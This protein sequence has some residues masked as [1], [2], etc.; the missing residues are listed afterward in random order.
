MKK[1][2]SQESFLEDPMTTL[3]T[4][5]KKA[6]KEAKEVAYTVVK[7]NGTLVPFRRERILRAIEAAFRDTKNVPEPTQFDTDVKKTIEQ[8]TD[9]VVKQVLLLASK[10]ACLTVEGIQDVVEVTLMKN[11]HHD[12][13][14]DYIVYRDERQSK[15]ETSVTNL[16]IYR[17]DK[18]T[19]TRFNPMKIASSIERAFRKARKI[20]EQSPDEVV[21]AVNLLTQKI[22]L[23]MSELSTKGDLLYIDMIEDRIERELMNEKFFDVAK[24]YILYRADKA[25]RQETLQS[26]PA[27]IDENATVRSFD[28]L[29]VDNV[30]IKINEHMIRNKFAFACRGLEKLT[31]ID[32]LLETSISQFY[33]GMKQHEADLAN[34]FSAKSKIEKE[35]AY[36]QVASRLL[37]D[38]LYRETVGL[39]ASDATLQKAH[40]QY[41]KKYIKEGISVERVSPK[42]LDFDLDELAAAMDLKRDDLFTYL[43]LQTLYDRYFIHHEQRRLET[44]QIFWMRVSMGLALN[45]GE[46]KNK[47]AIEFYNVLSQFHFTSSTP[48]LFNSG[49]LH[50][51]LS[52]CY[53]STVMDDLQHIFKVI[54]DDAQLSKY[55]GGLGNDWTNVRATGARIKGTNGNSQGVVPF[56]KVAND[57]AVAVNQ[58]FAPETLIYTDKGTKPISDIAIGDLVLGISGTYREVTEKF[59]YNQHDPMVAI[60]VKHSIDPISV[61]AGHPFYAIRGV[62]LEQANERTMQWLKKGKIKCEWVEAGQLQRGDYIAQVI[63]KETVAVAGMDEEDARLYG[64]LLGDGHMSK[65]G[66]QWGISGNPKSDTHLEFIRHYLNERG[67]H[68]WE[69]ECGD[70]YI[71][72]HWASGR[73]AV[74]DATTGRIV[75][76]GAPTLPFEY[77]DLYDAQGR[78]HIA[79]RLA[80]LPRPQ[81]L[82]LVQGL[83]ETD[84]NVSRGKEITF[85]NT[86]Q[87]LVEGLRYQ[88]LR[89]GVP[90]AGKLRVRKNDHTGRRSDGSLVH[91]KGETKN[92]DLR[93][94]A[95]PELAKLI[96]C[97]PVKKFN[98]LTINDHIFTRVEERASREVA[99]FV[100]DL[101]VEGDE[102]Y[103]TTSGLAHNGGKRKGA[104][105]AYL[106]TW[107]LDIEDFLELRKNTGDERRRTHDMNTANWIPDLFMKRVREGGMWTL[108]SP[109][110]VPDLHDLYGSA[111]EARYVAYEKM[112]ETGKIKLFKK[113]EAL[114]LWRKMLS[115]LFETGHPWITF[116]DPSNIRS[117]QDHVGVVH[118]SNLCTEILLNTSAQETAVCNLGS[119]N[120]AMHVTEK[121]LDEKQ[122]SSTIR[123]AVRMLDN[124]IDIN[125]Y[126]TVEAK[127]ANA[128][129]RPIGLGFMG[130]QDALY[131]QN[132][133]Y[134]SHAAVEFADKSMEM[135][136]YYAILAS[137]ELAQERGTYQTYKGSKWDRGLLPIDT[138]DI[139]EKERGVKVDIDRSMSM[140]WEPVRSAVKKYGMR[141]SNTMAIAPTATIA[142]ITGVIPSNEPIYKHLFVKSNLSGEFTVTNPH[143]V[144][145]LKEQNLWDDEMV[146]D[147]KYFDGSIREIER[148]PEEIRNLFLTAFEVEPEWIIECGARRQKW[149]DMGQSL[150]LYLAEP[151]GKKL[152]QM[153][154]L[155][156]EK[157]LKTTYYLRTL[158][159]TQIEKSS[160]D[161]NKRG[162]QPRWM[163]SKSASSNIKVD[164]AEEE[165]PK[166]CNLGEGCESCQ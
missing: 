94:P 3:K 140:N 72:I 65:E 63:P 124:V 112:T 35:P 68:F 20:E 51:Q 80:H 49:T 28:I 136:S 17:R 164:R 108:F 9:L 101:K 97:A 157:G 126:P 71:Q 25:L 21:A 81:A 19:P 15:R 151:S 134:A 106:E 46:Q 42:L 156:W 113:V 86:S 155:A 55:A 37:L 43:G 146:D 166:A 115:M 131:I 147:L 117:P 161:I 2:T 47:R 119:V 34:I 162:L 128:R 141:N 76:S 27:A 75:G 84:G 87:P 58:C 129:H 96:D 70:S 139:L 4:T 132:I 143:L 14:R 31:S 111:F 148:V 92:Y 114:Y 91:F 32:E 104:M 116:K 102:S 22:V 88:M 79:P 137:T 59:A 52:S 83:L 62:P 1:T 23:E 64:I 36:S 5:A 50:S 24:N 158:G 10:G 93:I 38:V 154:L 152:H 165:Q 41:F 61:T 95:I 39:P 44:P 26:L 107:H 127:T 133:S 109:S 78:K 60:T 67:I 159:A 105:C 163:K 45:E 122:L 18:T 73:G 48:T 66:A 160:I 149:I 30:T 138:I 82:A 100:Y 11:G 74:R 120:L 13:A 69:T 85:S 103:M 144:T 89:L 135:I 57:T 110:D 77:E 145:K 33:V 54:G 16:K 12:V 130:F 53:L 118:S 56:L 99:P 142:N 7:R 8:M 29:T 125:F 6:T 121:G 123:T 150:N 98:W 90:T 40:R 153:Y